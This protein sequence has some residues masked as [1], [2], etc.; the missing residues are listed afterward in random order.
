MKKGIENGIFRVL[1]YA[2]RLTH[3]RV[4]R[5]INGILSETQNKAWHISLG[6][7][8]KREKVSRKE[9]REKKKNSSNERDTKGEK[10]EKRKATRAQGYAKKVQSHRKTGKLERR[11]E[12]KGGEEKKVPV[13]KNCRKCSSWRC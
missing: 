4:Q 5:G 1:G 9:E 2:V 3:T 11:N 13:R 7:A 8:R 6:H 10:R 12:E